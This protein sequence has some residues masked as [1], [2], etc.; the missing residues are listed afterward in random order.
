M[1]LIGSIIKLLDKTLLGYEQPKQKKFGDNDI[2][3]IAKGLTKD[4][5]FVGDLIDKFG[6]YVTGGAHEIFP[7]IGRV[8]TKLGGGTLGNNDNKGE[9]SDYS[10]R[11]SNSGGE[12]IYLPDIVKNNRAPAVIN[13]STKITQSKNA[14]KLTKNGLLVTTTKP[15]PITDYSDIFGDMLKGRFD[16]SGIE[17]VKSKTKGKNMTIDNMNYEVPIKEKPSKKMNKELKKAHEMYE[18]E[19]HGPFSTGSFSDLPLNGKK[20]VEPQYNIH[21][22]IIYEL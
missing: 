1:A 22:D 11:S 9:A 10:K 4:I 20:Y 17:K 14:Y 5:P 15:P 21:D 6:P 16:L 8:M 7:F 18:V 19:A 13:K 2:G 3:K 12:V